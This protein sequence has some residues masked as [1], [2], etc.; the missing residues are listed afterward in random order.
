MDGVKSA[1][2]TWTV[3]RA[4]EGLQ[5]LGCTIF[6]AANSC[7]IVT[8]AFVAVANG[9]GVTK[10]L[11]QLREGGEHLWELQGLPRNYGRKINDFEAVED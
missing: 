4:G 7:A 1:M 10:G 11:H 9:S 5:G 6:T 8:D 2:V 3:G